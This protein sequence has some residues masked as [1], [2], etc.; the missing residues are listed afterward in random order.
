[1]LCKFGRMTIVSEGT[2]VFM[3]SFGDVSSVFPM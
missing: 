2:H 1:M 3:I